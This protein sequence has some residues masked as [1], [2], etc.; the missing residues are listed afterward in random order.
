[1]LS[2]VCEELWFL[3]MIKTTAFSPLWRLNLST[4]TK[5]KGC[6]EELQFISSKKIAT[7]FLFG[8]VWPLSWRP[9]FLHSSSVLCGCCDLSHG[10]YGIKFSPLKLYSEAWRHCEYSILVRL[11]LHIRSLRTV[12]AEKIAEALVWYVLKTEV[13]ELKAEA[14]PSLRITV[15]F[16]P[17]RVISSL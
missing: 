12:E 14:R 17:I 5:S 4:V 9:E 1:M 7:T 13:L 16:C 8:F 3:S 2:L 10:M 15:Y 11:K 6:C